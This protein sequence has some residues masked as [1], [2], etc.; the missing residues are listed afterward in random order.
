[1]PRSGIFGS[2][3]DGGFEAILGHWKNLTLPPYEITFALFIGV[4]NAIPLIGSLIVLLVCRRSRLGETPLT[5]S[6]LSGGGTFQPSLRR[7]RLYGFGIQDPNGGKTR[8]GCL[9]E[10]PG[11]V[12]LWRISIVERMSS[13]I[14]VYTSHLLLREMSATCGV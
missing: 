8:H 9:L 13:S 7:S 1:M 2:E 14:P 5:P 3:G 12:R 6:A 4:L 10:P 11:K